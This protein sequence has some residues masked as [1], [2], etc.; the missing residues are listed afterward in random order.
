MVCVASAGVG[1]TQQACL[2]RAG[3]GEGTPSPNWHPLLPSVWSLGERGQLPAG[4]AVTMQGHFPPS[5]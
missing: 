4:G 5:N 2:A 3:Y 1:G